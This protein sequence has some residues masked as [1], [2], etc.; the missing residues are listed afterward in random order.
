MPD[1]VA[2]AIDLLVQSSRVSPPLREAVATVEA[3]M[4][5]LTAENA[6][7]RNGRWGDSGGPSSIVGRAYHDG[8][9]AD[10]TAERDEMEAERDLMADHVNRCVDKL[11]VIRAE[12]DEARAALRE[13][14]DQEWTENVLDPQ[15][16]ARIARAALEGDDAT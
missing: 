16:A 9:V 10:L 13:I 7:L 3:E 2:R 5:R 4:E 8:V 1:P 12:R 14:R 6:K 11:N 15:W